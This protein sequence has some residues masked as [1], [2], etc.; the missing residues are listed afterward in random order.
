MG[1][2]GAEP[3]R[4]FP[5]Q[6]HVR[7]LPDAFTSGIRPTRH[8]RFV[9]PQSFVWAPRNAGR[10]ATPFK[11]LHLDS[12]VSTF[13]C[14]TSYQAHFSAGSKCYCYLQSNQTAEGFYKQPRTKIHL[15]QSVYGFSRKRWAVCRGQLRFSG[16]NQCPPAPGHDIWCPSGRWVHCGTQPTG[17]LIRCPPGLPGPA[18]QAQ[19]PA[20]CPGC[21]F[22]LCR[23]VLGMGIL[24]HPGLPPQPP[25]GR[26]GFY[27]DIESIFGNSRHNN[28]SDFSFC[29]AKL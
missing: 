24:A 22:G 12:A 20:P 21:S 19:K 11:I 29:T 16:G 14:R 15:P 17:S 23:Q 6:S 9:F 7:S 8:K 4:V 1:V 26:V 2:G 5:P 13:S 25:P 18:P 28:N 3:G 10:V 27:R